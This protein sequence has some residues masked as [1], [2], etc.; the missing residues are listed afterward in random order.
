MRQ[1]AKAKPSW[2]CVNDKLPELGEFV[3]YRTDAYRCLGKLNDKGEWLDY[4]GKKE[5]GTVLEWMKAD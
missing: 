4:T 3:F 2:N 5:A 1:D